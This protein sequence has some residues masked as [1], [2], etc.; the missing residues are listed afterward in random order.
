MTKKGYS[1][2]KIQSQYSCS[3]FR[4][5]TVRILVNMFRWV[6]SLLVSVTAWKVSVFGVFLV[7]IFPH[8]DWISLRILSEC[9]KILNRKPP[10][11]DTFHAVCSKNTD[12]KFWLDWLNFFDIRRQCSLL[13]LQVHVVVVLPFY[14]NK[15]L[16]CNSTQKQLR[17]C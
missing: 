4:I 5:L 14:G 9:R 16:K 1:I 2:K 10:N 8:L 11:T 3:N 13:C 17:F 15:R 12:S 7:R 6:H